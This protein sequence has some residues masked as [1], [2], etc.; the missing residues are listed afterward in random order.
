MVRVKR[1]TLITS[2]S[3]LNKNIIY[4][5]VNRD[6]LV[7]GGPCRL[8]TVLSAILICINC[9]INRTI[10]LPKIILRIFLYIFIIRRQVDNTLTFNIQSIFD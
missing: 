4:I 6:W 10:F 9:S 7:R 5:Y 1:F 8:Y 3:T 2:E